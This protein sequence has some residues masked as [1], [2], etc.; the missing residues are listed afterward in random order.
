MARKKT[1]KEW[2]PDPH[3]AEV[4]RPFYDM[5][6]NAY[7]AHQQRVPENTYGIRKWPQILVMY[8]YWKFWTDDLIQQ[9]SKDLA[10]TQRQVKAK[11]L[12]SYDK[13]ILICEAR[14]QKILRW[15]E[16]DEM[17]FQEQMKKLA[18][19]G[20]PEEVTAYMPDPQM[21]TLLA[22]LNELEGD[23]KMSKATLEV[24]P[25]VDQINEQK[26]IKDLEEQQ[27]R[28]TLQMKGKLNDKGT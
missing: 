11:Y 12:N 9:Q 24:A 23:M 13:Q 2:Q 26:V 10:E 27:E 28:H 7:T 25:I 14:I 8:K 15:M 3:M 19:S 6:I 18:E 20:K 21:E 17:A 1:P 5:G 16:E 22:K 4:L